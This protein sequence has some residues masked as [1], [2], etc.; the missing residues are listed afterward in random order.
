MGRSTYEIDQPWACYHYGRTHDAW[1]PFW[2]SS[3]FLGRACIVAECMVCGEQEPLWMRI[4]RF[5]TIPDRGHHPLR[6]KFLADH[7]HP[8]RG[9]PMSWAK[10]L[11]NP[12]AHKGALG[13]DL[14]GARLEADLNDA[15]K[16]GRD[17]CH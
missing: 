15:G 7:K 16:E 12:A 3:R 11:L 10:P 13:L 8:E 17:R 4:P 6:L 5:G 14:L 2:N 1:W 9:H